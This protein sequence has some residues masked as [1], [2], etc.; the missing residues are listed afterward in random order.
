[1]TLVSK[2]ACCATEHWLMS[3]GIAYDHKQLIF[4]IICDW[5]WENPPVMHY[6]KYLEMH[7]SI[8]QSVISQDLE[9]LR[10]QACNLP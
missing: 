5:L 9:Y 1:M 8:I 10:L 7:N 4:G 6:D 3:D 2:C